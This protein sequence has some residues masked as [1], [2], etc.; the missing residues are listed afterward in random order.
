[1]GPGATGDQGGGGAGGEAMEHVIIGAGPAG[2]VAAETLR[3][4]DPGGAVTIIGA[5]AEAPYVVALQDL[6]YL[7][8]RGP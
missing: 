2:V 8:H 5:E 3:T 1:M 4:C 7:E 6:E